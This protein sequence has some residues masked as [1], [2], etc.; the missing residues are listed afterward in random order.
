MGTPF[1]GSF[2]KGAQAVGKFLKSLGT[3]TAEGGKLH[4]MLEKVAASAAI[5][6]DKFVEFISK[7]DVEKIA[8]GM[9]KV[10]DVTVKFA[11]FLIDNWPLI[12]IIL[13]ALAI[14]LSAK[15]FSPFSGGIM[16]VIGTLIKFIGFIAMVVEILKWLGIATGTVG[17]G[18]TAV[19]AIIAG[20]IAALTSIVWAIGLVLVAVG[21]LYFA[22]KYNFMGITDTAKQLWFIIKYYFGLMV[23]WIVDSL[24]KINLFEL[25]R[26]ML[27]GLAGGIMNALPLII[28][29]LKNAGQAAIDAIKAILGIKSPSAAFKKLGELSGQGFSL[30][31]ANAMD[32]N[33]IAR[34]MAKPVQNMSSS[35]SS[36]NTFNLS[37]GLTIR[38]VDR[39]MDEKINR[40]AKRAMGGAA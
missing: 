23:K 32:P 34:S 30:G 2:D 19:S 5:L 1:L 7:L 21:L 18:F 6:V 15:N 37:G 11:G 36:S 8:T 38:D 31:L 22:F 27:Q 33:L 9:V 28:A 29:A 40:F 39:L 10:L 13:T 24:S 14:K 17:T 12:A 35:Q 4:P 20:T 3:M 16:G 26:N 25:G